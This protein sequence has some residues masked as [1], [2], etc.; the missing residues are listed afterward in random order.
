MNKHKGKSQMLRTLDE[1]TP[2]LRQHMPELVDRYKVRSLSVFGSYARREPREGSDLDLLVELDD[3]YMS[4]LKFVKLE[5]YLSDLLG[6]KVDLVE[7]DGLKPAISRRIFE[8]VMP[9]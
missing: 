3:P 2:I 4:L 7:K 5:N 9:I 6:V 1:L 8:E